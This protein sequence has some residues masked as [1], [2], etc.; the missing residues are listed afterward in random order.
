MPEAA[1]AREVQEV[2]G[3]SNRGGGESVRGKKPKILETTRKELRRLHR[4]RHAPV[5]QMQAFLRTTMTKVEKEEWEDEV[6]DLMRRTAEVCA[7]CRGCQLAE[8]VTHPGTRM[9]RDA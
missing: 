3:G 5:A 2:V 9:P 8:G 6:E 4:S 7:Q 1:P